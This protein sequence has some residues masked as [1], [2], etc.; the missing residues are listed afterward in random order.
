[1]NSMIVLIRNLSVEERITLVM[2]I[3][4]NLLITLV[5][6]VAP[7][8]LIFALNFFIIAVIF[9]MCRLSLRLKN[10]FLDVLRDWY[11][12]PILIVIYLE[13][14]ILIPLI[15]PHDLDHLM[16][17]I[18]RL[19]FF[20]H[21]PTVLM[22]SITFP[23]LSEILQLAY[24]SFYFLPFSL[25]VLLYLREDRDEFHVATSTILMGFYL[26][27]LGYYLTPVVGPR[28]T[29]DHLQSFPL[30][31]VL[32]FEYVR[33][34]LAEAEGMMRDCCPSGHTM[35]SLL[36]ALLARRYS[37]QLFS[38]AIVWACLIIFSTVYLRYHYVIDLIVGAL[39]GVL[40]FRYG[41]ALSLILLGKKD[42]HG[43]RAG[44]DA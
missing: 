17:A 42:S 5:D 27:Y 14:R 9:T 10:P 36:T 28:F 32:T 22:E 20:G 18:D 30:T 38:C 41:P 1:M 39:L 25:C 2:A 24:A 3:L 6:Q 15:N 26:S 43:N 37:R 29:L 7:A 16:I 11:V 8:R 33:T 13:N 40:V 12:L 35:I 21:D 4:L 31:G 34:M 19:I 23:L 44:K